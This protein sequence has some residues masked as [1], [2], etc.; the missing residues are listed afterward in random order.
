VLGSHDDLLPLSL[1]PSIANVAWSSAT[2]NNPS[3]G[4]TANIPLPW[5]TGDA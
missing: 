5:V 1:A 2:P 3:P 4:A